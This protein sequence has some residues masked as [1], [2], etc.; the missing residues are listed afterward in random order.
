M[1][2]AS[3][4]DRPRHFN[5]I[6]AL[7]PQKTPRT[8]KDGLDCPISHDDP[9]LACSESGSIR[10]DTRFCRAPP[11]DKEGTGL[12]GHEASSSFGKGF[13]STRHLLILFRYDPGAPQQH[14]FKCGGSA[15]DAEKRA[16]LKSAPWGDFW[17]EFLGAPAFRQYAS[18]KRKLLRLLQANRIRT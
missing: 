18:L 1:V 17:D 4:E 14:T 15:E 11:Y 10:V 6:A 7:D 12:P 8:V 13:R 2:S 9:D 16:G 3:E 5:N